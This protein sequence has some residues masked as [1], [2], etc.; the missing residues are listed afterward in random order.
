MSGLGSRDPT[1]GSSVEAVLAR[2]LQVVPHVLLF[3]IFPETVAYAGS[4]INQA[5][6]LVA[7][8]SPVWWLA[9]LAEV[10]LK[11]S[12]GSPASLHVAAAG[13]PLGAPVMALAAV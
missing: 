9:V 11:R 6:S 2:R 3:G 8:R 1:R 5:Q 7:L 12:F 4:G 10:G 13:D